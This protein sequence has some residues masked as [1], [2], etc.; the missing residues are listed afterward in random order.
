MQ[1]CIAK[2][3]QTE[4][5]LTRQREASEDL[6]RDMS[7]VDKQLRHNRIQEFALGINTNDKPVGSLYEI[8]WETHLP[9]LREMGLALAIDDKTDRESSG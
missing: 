9:K 5:P 4:K 7:F 1:H 6:S 3:W 8:P 2:T